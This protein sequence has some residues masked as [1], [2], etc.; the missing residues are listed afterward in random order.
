VLVVT[1]RAGRSSLAQ[2]PTITAANVPR[3]PA[4]FSAVKGTAQIGGATVRF[5]L[6][7]RIPLVTAMTGPITIASPQTGTL[8]AQGSAL[9][10]PGPNPNT[11][12]HSTATGT[13]AQGLPFTVK[14]TYTATSGGWCTTLC[15][16]QKGHLTIDITGAVTAR[17]DGKVGPSLKPIV[18]NYYQ[19]LADLHLRR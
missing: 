3:I 12:I 14:W 15:G 19:I 2:G 8:T 16:T 6:A 18:R 13:T 4:A 11:Q 10:A 7:E 5:N 9:V 1:D 17:F